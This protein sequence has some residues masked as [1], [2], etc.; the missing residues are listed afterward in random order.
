LSRRIPL[1]LAVAASGLLLYA[2]TAF[3]APVVLWSDSAVDLEWARTGAGIFRPVPPET[4]GG[5]VP[6]HP[7]K[8][9]YLLFLRAAQTLAPAG[10]EGRTVVV[11]QSFLLWLSI[12]GT[13]LFLLR[14]FGWPAIVVLA[15]LLGFLRLRDS[16][17]AVMPEALCAA[18]FLPI[19]ARLLQ[20]PRSRAGRAFL[21]LS[22][23]VLFW[24][25]PNAGGIVLVLALVPQVRR[26]W[27]EALPVLGGFG[28]LFL[29]IWFLTRPADGG[30]L[31]GLSYPVLEAS[32]DYYWMPAG[33]SNPGSR[34]DLQRRDLARAAANWK[35]LLQERG[36]DARRQLVFRSLRGILATE[37]SD[38]RWSS[39]YRVLAIASRLATPLMT[40]AAIAA[41][42]AALAGGNAIAVAGTVL[43]LLL[44]GQNLVVGPNPRYVL[45][46]LPVLLALGVL[47]L[48]QLTPSRRIAFV[49]LF[50]LLVVFV[51]AHPFLV[52]QE[53]GRIES[54]GVTLRQ[55]IPR[56]SLP[57]GEPATLHV[58]I[59]PPLVPSTANL[60]VRAGGVLL[61]DPGSTT[62]DRRRPAIRAALP[63]RV[64]DA[65]RTGPIELEI[66][67]TGAYGPLHYLLFPVIPPPWR[68]GARRAGSPEISPTTGIGSG[69]LDWWAH[70]GRD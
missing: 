39:V 52:D 50:V 65:N 42:I 4:A 1:F 17:S 21:G 11:L 19:A 33:A 61:L 37:Y 62:A 53:W 34:E 27:K 6:L 25:R 66:T 26:G 60:E 70:T 46:F 28:L 32:T 31:R 68:S 48:V 56:G 24:V 63:Q 44:V 38:S 47:S 13:S 54:E 10:Q 36:P 40:L 57:R 51:A 15:V 16:A 59:A 45:P 22:I 12:A 29:P 5:E 20:P 8:P 41:I 35:A 67:S 14:H 69:A 64:M 30:S 9:A 49:A 55:P 3:R 43:F 23:A 58:R 18:L 7:A 2:W